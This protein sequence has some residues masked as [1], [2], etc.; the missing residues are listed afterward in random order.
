MKRMICC[1]LAALLLLTALSGCGQTDAG[2]AFLSLLTDDSFSRELKGKEG[3]TLAAQ[4]ERLSLYVNGATAAFYVEDRQTGARWHSAAEE[5]SDRFRAQIQVNY[6]NDGG[7]VSSL[8]SYT[9]G[10]QLSQFCW[11]KIDN[12]MRV[13]Y[14]IGK[15]KKQYL[16]PT[17]ISEARMKSK[18]LAN[19]D[20]DTQADLLGMYSYKSLD[21]IASFVLR[22]ELLKTYPTLKD[23]PLYVVLD[24]LADF[25]RT[26]LEKY[27]IA[28]GYTQEDLEQDDAENGVVEEDASVSFRV[29]MEYL[30]DGDSLK[31][32][33]PLAEVS[34]P[35]NIYLQNLDVLP[36]FGAAGRDDEGYM[37]LPDGCGALIDLNNG[38]QSQG[39]YQM[40]LYGKD[41]SMPDADPL[42]DYQLLSLPV[43][44]MKRQQGSF[45]TVI[46]DGAALATL[47]AGVSDESTPLNY[48]Y[49]S[50]TV[51]NAV[52]ADAGSYSGETAIYFYQKNMPTTDLT[53]RY[54]FLSPEKGD[55]S[56]M[57]RCY[58]TYLQA[59]GV[60]GDWAG[61]EVPFYLSLL[62]AVSKEEQVMGVPVNRIHP[63]TTFDEAQTIVSSLTEKG[64]GT[65]VARYKYWCNGADDH[66]AFSRV[67]VQK[68]L[69]GLEGLLAF[70]SFMESAGGRLYW[71]VDLQNVFRGTLFDGYSGVADSPK[72]VIGESVFRMTYSSVGGKSSAVGQLLSPM[73]YGKMAAALQKAFPA[74]I[75][76]NLSL[77]ALGSTLYSD[78]DSSKFAD[79]ETASA[80]AAEVF[81]LFAQ[82]GRVLGDHP[83][84]YVLP[85]LSETVEIPT[86][87]NGHYLTD[88]DVPFYQM[89]LHGSLYYAGSPLNY[90]NSVEEETLRLIETGSMPY[91][92][93]MYAENSALH[94]IQ[95]DYSAVSYAEWL[96]EAVAVYQTV[97][98]AL[99]GLGSVSIVSH[100]EAAPQV[101]CTVYENGTRIYVNYADEAATVQNV[102]VA[103]RSY[104]VVKGGEDG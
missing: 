30:L 8:N 40:P 47:R 93:W 22:E 3:Y 58:R 52:L 50:F 14:D 48:V 34:C 6:I 81:A 62:G 35:R 99:D 72:S 100:E 60:L 70:Q 77:N 28:S 49:P 4:N 57:A 73:R 31:V 84:A 18:I 21:D 55:Y 33:V 65:V 13:T 46:E 17:V 71:D 29:P 45:L 88:R 56:G 36:Y 5:G 92:E 61:D 74:Q 25:A 90:A 66:T 24:G 102:S 79:R 23:G 11:E 94:S 7:Q 41:L 97:S 95:T 67:K 9:D 1:L 43:Y 69:G 2:T 86:R 15:R 32:R 39:T 16:I 63:L 104:A 42:V 89:V 10:V 37:L 98:R 26:R 19:L 76:P 101:Y 54:F 53:L 59:Q 80:K 64:V 83:S 85:Y 20:E 91:F 96:D 38:K 82:Q 27:V 12:G 87:S 68:Q 103:A 75:T 51:Y 78:F 44:G